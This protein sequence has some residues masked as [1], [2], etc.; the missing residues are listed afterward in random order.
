MKNDFM[1]NSY[2]GITILDRNIFKEIYIG[3]IYLS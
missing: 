2:S 3:D 1:E